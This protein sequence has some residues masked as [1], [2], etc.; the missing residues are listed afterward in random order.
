MELITTLATIPAILALVTIAKDQ[1]LPTRW[2]PVLAIVLG[3]ALAIFD[4]LAIS[5]GSVANWYEPVAK[6]VVLGL[7]AS[8]L[9][10]G[11]RA[12]GSKKTDGTSSGLS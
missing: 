3:V 11:A 5:Q 8:G 7:S 12:I 4:A 9:Y 2:A 6:G 10:D 1:G